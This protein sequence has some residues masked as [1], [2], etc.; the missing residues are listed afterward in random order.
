MKG[1]APQVGVVVLDRKYDGIRSSS[2]SITIRSSGRSG[3][4]SR[5]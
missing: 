4:S 3:F 2:F 1:Y 5:K